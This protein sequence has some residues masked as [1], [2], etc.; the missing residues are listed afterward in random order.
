MT[1][2]TIHTT[3]TAPEASRP[4]LEQA[5]KGL[6]F[7][8]NLY[9]ALA[10]APAL[11]K[12]YTTVSQIFDGSSLSP[13]E[14]QVVLLTTS[15]ENRCEYC[16]AAHSAIAGMQKVPED[17]IAALRSGEALADPKL[18][19]LRELT[20]TAVRERGWVPESDV[21]AFLDAGYGRQQ[22]LEVVLGIG[23]K[24]MSNFTNHLSE[25]PLDDAFQ[26]QAWAAPSAASV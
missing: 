25:T 10:A 17:V 23:L 14:R 6:G 11:L 7:V 24:T 21:Q 12:A 2:F 22:V 9:G 4:I 5:R 3:E 26:A 8:P 18:Q 20:R 1:A 13:T 19:A 16:M 15:F